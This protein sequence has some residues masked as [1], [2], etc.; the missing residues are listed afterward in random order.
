MRNSREVIKKD[1]QTKVVEITRVT[2]VVAGG[3]RMRFRALVVA[4]DRKGRVGIG[5]K[6]GT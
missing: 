2:R 3:K 5:V 1:F 6:K 4:G